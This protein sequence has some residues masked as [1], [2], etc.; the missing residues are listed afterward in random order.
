MGIVRGAAVSVLLLTS[1]VPA[2]TQVATERGVS[3]ASSVGATV[4]AGVELPF[5]YD[6]P[7]PPALPATMI[8]DEQGRTTVR[9]VRL[10]AP[11]KIDGNLDEALYETVLPISDFIQVEPRPGEPATE[12]TEVWIAFDENNVY[13]S[14][15]AWE[16]HPER[17]VVNE[18]RRDGNNMFQNEHI[19]FA[20]DTFYD[21]RN[22]LNFYFNPIGGRTDGQNSN[23]G[24]WN[25][26][27]NP[28]W[29]FAVRRNAEGWT[30]E[31]AVP[32]TSLRYRPG[33]AQIWG[34][35][36]RRTDRWKNEHSFLTRLPNGL[37]Q[38][39]IQR[40]SRGATLVGIEAPSG[41]R[42]MEI[43]PFATSS[44][45]SD[46]TATPQVQSDLG[47]DAG[48]DFK[49]GITKNLTTD[50]TLNTDFA[51]VEADEQQVNLTRFS[52][53]FPEKRDFFIE[54]QGVFNFGGVAGNSAGDTPVLFYSRRI[55]LDLGR[56]SPTASLS[57]HQ[58]PIDAGGRLTGRV[59]R[60][61]VG[62]LDMQTRGES[63]FAIPS[64]NFGVLRLKRDIL[65]RSAVGALYTRRSM[66]AD[67]AG[68]AETYGLDGTFAFYSNLTI[69]SYWAKTKSPFVSG[70][71]MSYRGQFNYNGDRYGL[72]AERLVVGDNFIPEAGFVRRDNI[73]KDA[74]TVRFSPRPKNIR[75]VRKFRY[76]GSINYIENGGGRLESREV[77]GEYGIDFQNSDGV[78]ISYARQYEYLPS[79]F[80]IATGVTL[81]VGPYPFG[82]FRG[83]FT[84]GQQRMASGTV[85]IE[86]GSFYSG[87]RTAYG[88]SGGR[89]KVN[90]HVYIEPGLSVNRVVLPVGEFTAKL[91][92]SRVT[93]TMTPRMFVSGLM[94][95]NSSNS[96][97]ST[98]LRLRWEYQPGSEIFVVYN[99]SR[100]TLPP[101]YPTLQN[102]ALVFKI[103]RL[104][105]L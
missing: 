45:L 91:V 24:Q 21:R 2:S 72:Q 75:S 94:Q 66:R 27:W 38:N 51:Q 54:N 96:S 23:E 20:F 35:Q 42:T 70:D 55:G 53:F 79:P 39:G 74:A 76:E 64:S 89:V 68:L 87:D 81:P 63:A 22:S 85:Y 17:M 33:R 32:F 71:D 48:L 41:S 1:G 43:K 5:A 102:R 82:T 83:Q 46:L 80:R 25:A 58:V 61:T 29:N 78:E 11:L 34:V 47:K 105:R 56:P 62:V 37:G 13:V 84:F 15:R 7:P 88:Y 95:Y 100:D 50:F 31:A 19:G 14:V 103:N 101:G 57:Q 18:M 99:E 10:T 86:Q 59:G 4:I 104:F 30:G 92:S 77:R 40:T 49:Y 36:F 67:G 65:R 3:S 60:V 98:N 9:A 90:P 6:G 69:N 16:S 44:L 93:Y 73:Q 97:L 52:L 26:D 8:R 12:K 28:I